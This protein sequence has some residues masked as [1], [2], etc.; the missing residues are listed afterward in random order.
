MKKRIYKKNTK[1]FKKI[2]DKLIETRKS[3]GLDKKSISF[4]TEAHH[5][6]PRCLGGSDSE[7]NLVL[8]SFREH[9]IAHLL[10]A[11]IYD[12]C[13]ELSHAADLMYFSPKNSKLPHDGVVMTTRYL[14]EL[15]IKSLNFLQNEKKV[16][17]QLGI[18]F[19]EERKKKMSEALKGHK[20]SEHSREVMS[21]IS[22]RP[23]KGPD[24][25]VYESITKCSEMTPYT[26][27]QLDYFLKRKPSMGFSYVSSKT[28]MK[29]VID[30]EGNVY[31][32]VRHYRP[33]RKCLSK[34]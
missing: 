7:E 8:L 18:R 12:N 24:G 27:R 30:P 5:I 10:L 31:P 22:S 32:S 25:T 13:S 4:Y 33:R 28:K 3:R 29:K 14:E 19:P 20:N 26:R 15:K 9:I 34:C 21:K 23:I 2:Y 11:R 6:I 17:G 1:I 16:I